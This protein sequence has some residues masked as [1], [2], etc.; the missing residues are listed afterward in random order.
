LSPPRLSVLLPCFNHGAFLAEAIG[1]VLA[2]TFQDFEIILVDDGSTDPA[3]AEQIRNCAAPRT[4]IFRIE[5]RGLSGAR[6][7]AASQGEGA[8][9][10]ALAADDRLAPAWFEKAVARLD[11]D[12]DLG[13]VSHW[14]RAFG[15]ETWEWTPQR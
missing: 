8:L 3:T 11:A 4:R 5:N 7:F 10:C 9:F 13:F 1:S 6:N 14:L 2:Q 15:D 12:A